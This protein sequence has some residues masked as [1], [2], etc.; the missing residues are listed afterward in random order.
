MDSLPITEDDLFLKTNFESMIADDRQNKS[1]PHMK[2][3]SDFD[4]VM[5][6][7]KDEKAKDKMHACGHDAHM[8]MLLGAQAL[9]KDIE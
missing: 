7:N 1:D 6:S 9:L 4:C 3:Q 2:S 8:S 5:N